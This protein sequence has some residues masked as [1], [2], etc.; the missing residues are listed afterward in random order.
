MTPAS[1]TLKHGWRMEGSKLDKIIQPP[2]E[3]HPE[4]RVTKIM[5]FQEDLSK[6]A[7][8]TIKLEKEKNEIFPKAGEKLSSDAKIFVTRLKQIRLTELLN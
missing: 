6:R 5:E 3:L 7:E 8:V 4:D 1:M 2:E